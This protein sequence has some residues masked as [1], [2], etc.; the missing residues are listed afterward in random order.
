MDLAPNLRPGD[1]LTAEMVNELIRRTQ[2][3]QPRGG[4]GIDVRSGPGGNHQFSATPLVRFVA[5][6]NGDISARSGS[7]WGTGSVTRYQFDGTHDSTTSV[8]YDV[9]NPSSNTMS[10][11]A[12][13][14]S[15]LYCFV[16][17]DDDGN[18]VV[19]PLECS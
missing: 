1:P 14:T 18:L 6:A 12:G 3:S 8:D 4:T 10:G 13:I 11:G 19:S 7:T 16:A 17:E 2:P 15:G 5:V 9:V